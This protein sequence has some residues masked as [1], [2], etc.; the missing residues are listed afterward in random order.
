MR[1]LPPALHQASAVTDG[2]PGVRFLSDW[3]WNEAARCYQVRCRLS[4]AVVEDGP[5][6]AM[7]EWYVSV[8]PDY[9]W[10]RIEFHPLKSGLQLTFQHQSYNGLGS[11]DLPY[12]EGKICLTL[13]TQALRRGA[14]KHEP[15]SVEGRLAWY[16]ERAQDWLIAASHDALALPGESFELPDFPVERRDVRVVFNE[17]A[18]SFALWQASDGL[19]GTVELSGFEQHTQRFLLTTR[20]RSDKGHIIY[21]PCWEAQLRVRAGTVERG[22]WLRLKQPPVVWPWQ[23]PT[24]WDELRTAVRRQQRQTIDQLVAQVAH[25]FRDGRSHILLVGFPLP[26]KVGGPADQLHWQPLYLPVLSHGRQSINGFRN[27]EVGYWERDRRI[28][29]KEK[30][31]NEWLASENWAAHEVSTRGRLPNPVAGARVLLLGAGAVGSVVAAQLVRAGLHELTIM[32]GDHLEIG[33]LVRHSLGL[34]DVGAM[35][36][37]ALA[38][39]L[40]DAAP[41]ARIVALA[42]HFP[43]RDPGLPLDSSSVVLDCTSDD[44]VLH[45]LATYPWPDERLFISLSLGYYARRLFCFVARGRSF[46]AEDFHRRLAPWLKRERSEYAAAELPRDGRGCWHPL[47]PAR[48]DDVWLM[49]AM[50]VKQVIASIARPPDQPELYV[51]EQT[52]QDGVPTGVRHVELDGQDG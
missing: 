15:Y 27:N 29:L 48:A 9:P 20:F 7:T 28:V 31:M 42:D 3:Q 21:E 5:I 16:F 45:K 18:E 25:H 35:K 39:H 6:P 8:D 46:P 12:R 2:M 33:N 37:T 43:P 30:R 1:R 47:F 38:D 32:D 51:F 14:L 40:M 22:V 19:V 10:G 26:E 24:T 44:L 23:A 41:H 4:A 13:P 11:P 52:E 50:A 17:A 49:S 34:K 36:A